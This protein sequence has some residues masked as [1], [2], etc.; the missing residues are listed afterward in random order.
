MVDF[1]CQFYDVTC[2]FGHFASLRREAPQLV[3][4]TKF[5]MASATD[6]I[7]RVVL[8]AVCIATVFGQESKSTFVGSVAKFKRTLWPTGPGAPYPGHL[9]SPWHLCAFRMS[10]KYKHDT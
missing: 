9:V 2:Y 5:T 3:I 10:I 8:M 1:L 6:M 4:F 7:F